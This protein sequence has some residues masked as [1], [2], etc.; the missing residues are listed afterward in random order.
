[1]PDIVPRE[2]WEA[3]RENAPPE[4]KQLLARLDEARRRE[5]DGAEAARRA[6]EGQDRAHRAAFEAA[7]AA[8]LDAEGANW[9]RPYRQD[10]AAA[11]VLGFTRATLEH[12]AVFDL[13]PI[14]LH[15]VRL[16]L[17]FWPERRGETWPQTERARKWGTAGHPWSVVLPDGTQM[18][19]PTLAEAVED[20]AEFLDRPF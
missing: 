9:L 8:R 13:T 2:Q 6:A 4:V 3:R 14:G 12:W 10:D 17:A 11:G 5:R 18:L 1:M 16:H 15:P 7:A 19:R 20:A